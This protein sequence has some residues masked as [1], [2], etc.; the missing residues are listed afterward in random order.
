MFD[1]TSRTSGSSRSM[2]A[3][4]T[5]RPDSQRKLTFRKRTRPPN[6]ELI[7]PAEA[8]S[9][10][11]S[12]SLIGT[13]GPFAGDSE[14]TSVDGRGSCVRSEARRQNGDAFRGVPAVAACYLAGLAH[15]KP[16]GHGELLEG[17]SALRLTARRP[18]KSLI[19]QPP[20]ATRVF[21]L[22]AVLAQ[23]VHGF[24]AVPAAYAAT[25]YQSKTHSQTE[26]ARSR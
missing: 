13:S 3:V 10:V 7:R 9:K 16:N 6:S 15:L 11:G 14:R 23:F 5:F 21:S 17:P 18:E 2:D 12:R 20:R 1:G 4:C 19:Q 24:N 22:L 25:K 26:P 8:T